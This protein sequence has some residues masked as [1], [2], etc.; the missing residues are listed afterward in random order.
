MQTLFDG[1]HGYCSESKVPTVFKPIT[2]H[3]SRWTNARASNI[4]KYYNRYKNSLVYIDSQLESIMRI[5]DEKKLWQNTI[6]IITSDHGEEFDDNKLGYLGHSS[7]YTKYQLKVPILIH[8]PHRKPKKIIY[9]TTHYDLVP[10]LVNE[11]L[12]CKMADSKYSIGKNIFIPKKTPFFIAGSYVNSGVITDKNIFLLASNGS[13]TTQNKQA[14][15]IY[16][17]PYDFVIIKKAL[18]LMRKF[19][20]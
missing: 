9:K 16:N 19:Y 5:L 1:V 18:K 13:I 17:E 12:G 10:T 11:L 2:K 3:C 14:K 15:Q 7:N 4:K 20:A 8:W 6:V